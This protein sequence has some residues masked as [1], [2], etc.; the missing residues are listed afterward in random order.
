MVAPPT[1]LG[2]FLSLAAKCHPCALPRE[3]PAS[4]AT[5]CR[6]RSEA[7]IKQV[8][9]PPGSWVTLQWRPCGSCAGP[10][11]WAQVAGPRGAT[12]R[13]AVNYLPARRI[14]FALFEVISSARRKRMRE[15]KTPLT[16]TRL[17]RQQRERERSSEATGASRAHSTAAARWPV[18]ECCTSAP[19]N[20]HLLF[21]TRGRGPQPEPGN[22]TIRVHTRV[23]PN[24]PAGVCLIFCPLS[25]KQ[26][27]SQVAVCPRPYLTSNCSPDRARNH[28]STLRVFHTLLS[29]LASCL[30]GSQLKKEPKTR[31]Q[32]GEIETSTRARA[33]KVAARF[34]RSTRVDGTFLAATKSFA[35]SSCDTVSLGLKARHTNGQIKRWSEEILER[36]KS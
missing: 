26:S 10:K 7:N 18:R 23:P 36:S 33:T 6:A 20:N 13:L 35:T 28:C 3:A 1:A 11:W 29:Y 21:A 30:S 22:E 27:T 8:P 16:V 19:N 9:P 14:R 12:S 32:E 31:A 17:G 2:A 5:C 34:L 4:R 15:N 25:R 24:L